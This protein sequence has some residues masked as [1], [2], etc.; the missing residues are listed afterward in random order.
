MEE[1][2]NRATLTIKEAAEPWGVCTDTIRC[3]LDDPLEAAFVRA[4]GGARQGRRG[5]AIRLSAKPFFAALDG[6]KQ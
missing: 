6:S 2:R 1:V 3:Y 5:R 4:G